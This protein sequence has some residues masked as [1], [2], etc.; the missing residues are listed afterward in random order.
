MS[1][2]NLDNIHSPCMQCFQRLNHQYDK[3]SEMCQ[4]CE[5]NIAIQ[6]LKKVLQT[7]DYCSLC[8]NRIKL[9]GGYWDC[10]KNLQDKCTSDD[11][12]ID[13]KSAFEDYVT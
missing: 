10:K 12:S 11:F 6:L 4:G 5:Y 1:K 3:D 7:N 8:Q 9:G 13:W 2:V